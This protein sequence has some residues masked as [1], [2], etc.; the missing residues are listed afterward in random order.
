MDLEEFDK[1]K[2]NFE[3]MSKLFNS[4]DIDPVARRAQLKL[5]TLETQLRIADALE[6]LVAIQMPM[7]L[8]MP[9]QWY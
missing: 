3:G 1:I 4:D 9:N 7:P 8:K 6:A 2:A 5:A